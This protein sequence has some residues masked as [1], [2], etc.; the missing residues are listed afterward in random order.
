MVQEGRSV[1]RVGFIITFD[2]SWL[3]G[4]SY[5]RNLLT[6]IYELPDRKIEPV[7]FTDMHMSAGRFTDF[8]PF[9]VVH[10]RLLDRFSLPWIVRKVWQRS[11]DQDLLLERLLS[12][13]HIS[14]LSHSVQLGK[15]ASI[16][17]IGWIPDFQ[18]R[19]MPEF[20]STA[21]LAQRE[22]NFGNVLMCNR[23][24]VSSLDAQADIFA[25]YP[26]YAER[27]RVLQFVAGVDTQVN[28]PSLD[29]VKKKY[30]IKSRYFHLPNQFWI[31][32]NHHVVIEALRILKEQGQHVVVLATG[33]QSDQRRTNHF[34]S[35]MARVEECGL[36]EEFRVIGIVPYPELMVLMR[37]SVALLNPSFFE[38]WSTTV[39]ESKA[40]GKR[41]ILSDIPVHREQS[42]ARGVYF[43]PHNPETLAFAMKQQLELWNPDEDIDCAI[44]SA[45]ALLSRRQ[46][47]AK[48]Y[49]EIVLELGS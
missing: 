49:Q 19:R 43:N 29:E 37:H 45:S 14:V 2:G 34:Q 48:N 10:S 4:I 15:Q 12:K 3:G 36:S 20:F 5:F 35:L 41:I 31:H 9:E 11:F 18:H 24:I 39:E 38:G 23:V 26:N 47:F 44:Q 1:I 22:R 30:N 25:F 27:S 40:L 16:P 32:K 33:N 42:P 46:V 28:C 7:I 17:T 8:P 6:A 21:E 13:H